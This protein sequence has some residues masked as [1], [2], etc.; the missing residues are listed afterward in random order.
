MHYIIYTG[1]SLP[2]PSPSRSRSSYV[3]LDFVA[4]HLGQITVCTPNYMHPVPKY[5]KFG[6][7]NASVAPGRVVNENRRMQTKYGWDHWPG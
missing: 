7:D 2:S 3:P 5:S 4:P 1:T 6:E